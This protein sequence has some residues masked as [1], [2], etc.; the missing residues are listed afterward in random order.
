MW[1]RSCVRSKPM[2]SGDVKR[3]LSRH[4]ESSTAGM[5]CSSSEMQKHVLYAVSLSSSTCSWA[6][7]VSQD[8]SVLAAAW[9]A[10]A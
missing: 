7:Q 2:W 5:P 3:Q 1:V 10:P 6:R 8:T 4:G 9:A